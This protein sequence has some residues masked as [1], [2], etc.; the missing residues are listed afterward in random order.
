MGESERRRV[1]LP[2]FLISG[3]PYRRRGMFSEIRSVHFVGVC[4]TAMASTAAALKQRGFAVTGSDQNVRWS[5]MTSTTF[6]FVPSIHATP[7]LSTE[8]CVL[9]AAEIMGQS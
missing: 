8:T 9:G 7:D 4:G 6:T 3:F 1:A 5:T 2:A